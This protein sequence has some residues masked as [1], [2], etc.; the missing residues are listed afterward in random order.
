LWQCGFLQ[1]EEDLAN[2]GEKVIPLV[3]ERDK[4]LEPETRSGCGP[5][6]ATSV[7]P[8]A[9][10]RRLPLTGGGQNRRGISVGHPPLDR[11][12]PG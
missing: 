2:F 11:H 9:D 4:K 8:G 7:G 5:M 10:Q 1:Y 3:R 6:T 12:I